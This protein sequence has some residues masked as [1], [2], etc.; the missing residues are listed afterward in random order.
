M[1]N[2]RSMLALQIARRISVLKYQPSVTII[3]GANATGKTTLSLQV[4]KI[5]G[6]DQCVL[7]DLDDYQY[8]RAQKKEQGITGQNPKGTKLDQARLDIIDLKLERP[9]FKPRYEFMTGQILDSE[10]VF[11]SRHIIING[12]SAFADEIRTLADVSVF[13]EASGEE[14][15]RRRLK[16]D[17][18]ER[19]YSE[20]RVRDLFPDLKKD[21]ERFIEP[22]KGEAGLLMRI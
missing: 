1:D 17:I 7:I 2:R 10:I 15:M 9:I 20:E 13:L 4:V 22:M 21:Y 8:S 3:G 16:R 5:L 11:P 19:G 12:T 18:A 14:L 6:Q